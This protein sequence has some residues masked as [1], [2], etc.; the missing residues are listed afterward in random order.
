[1][2]VK[3]YE[4]IINYRPLAESMIIQHLDDGE[5]FEIDDGWDVDI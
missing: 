2:V 4:K 1:M 5:T 3:I